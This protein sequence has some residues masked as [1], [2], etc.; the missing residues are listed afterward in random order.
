[1]RGRDGR[2]GP[3]RRA[4]GLESPRRA[5]LAY[6]TL[7]SVDAVAP[8]S[9]R[10][11]QPAHSRGVLETDETPRSVSERSKLCAAISRCDS[12]PRARRHDGD[13]APSRS[14]TTYAQMSPCSDRDARRLGLQASSY[15]GPHVCS[16]V[17]LDCCF[18]VTKAALK[19]RDRQR[20]HAIFLE[21]RACGDG[22][23]KRPP[24][25]PKRCDGGVLWR[26]A[27][28]DGSGRTRDERVNRVNE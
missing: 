21:N 8:S 20:V 18:G 9:D 24:T 28:A 11:P 23:R 1:M 2:R 6:T 3:A 22:A 26:T 10:T 5:P 27:G 25:P 7:P 14:M 15:M 16:A 12:S 17:T 19:S 13:R 4:A